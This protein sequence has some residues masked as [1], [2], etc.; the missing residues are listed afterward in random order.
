MKSP[1]R[2]CERRQFFFDVED[3]DGHFTARPVDGEVVVGV[4]V[5]LGGD[6]F[7]EALLPAVLVGAEEIAGLGLG[8]DGGAED[9]AGA[10]FGGLGVVHKAGVGVHAA[11][12]GGRGL[13]G[14][15]GEAGVGEEGHDV[16][17][18]GVGE[19]FLEGVVEAAVRELGLVVALPA[20]PGEAEGLFL[21]AVAPEV[22]ALLVEVLGLEIPSHEARLGRVSHDSAVG[23]LL[24]QRK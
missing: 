4:E 7:G 21:G 1:R 3:S 22:A 12:G 6:E 23:A 10:V 5:F 13:E 18:V 20:R 14:R 11:V 8:V 15:Q 16:G 24:Q 2:V 9:A 19:L 17:D